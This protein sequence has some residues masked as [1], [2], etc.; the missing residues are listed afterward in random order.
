MLSLSLLEVLACSS[1]RTDRGH[2]FVTR[3]TANPLVRNDTDTGEEMGRRTRHEPTAVC[4]GP[5]SGTSICLLRARVRTENL[6]S[7]N[8]GVMCCPLLQLQLPPT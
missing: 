3:S 2:K 1:Q 5:E 8:G 7:T 4:C 6:R